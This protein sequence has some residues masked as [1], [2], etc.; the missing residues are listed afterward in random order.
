VFMRLAEAYREMLQ[1]GR[2]GTAVYEGALRH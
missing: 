1:S 2:H